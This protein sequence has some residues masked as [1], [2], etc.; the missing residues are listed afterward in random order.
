MLQPGA[1]AVNHHTFLSF[2]LWQTAC[3][4]PRENYL[5][6]VWRWATKQLNKQQQLRSHLSSS[7][8][9]FISAGEGHQPDAHWIQTIANEQRSVRVLH[10]CGLQL[11]PGPGW[12][13]QQPA[14]TDQ[15]PCARAFTQ[16]REGHRLV[17]VWKCSRGCTQKKIVWILKIMKI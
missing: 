9:F 8:W 2:V 11:L 15:W 4:Q 3:V 7:V 16:Q 10:Q 1:F 12:G 17:R 6:H 5:N 13:H 14:Y